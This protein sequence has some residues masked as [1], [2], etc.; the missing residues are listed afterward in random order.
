MVV[1]AE[2]WFTAGALAQ[3]G[4]ACN[5]PAKTVALAE[6]LEDTF[7]KTPVLAVRL[8]LK[9]CFK[10]LLGSQKCAQKCCLGR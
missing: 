3:K 5:K 7:A 9:F 2:R 6:S 8:C 10:Q 4:E 1:S